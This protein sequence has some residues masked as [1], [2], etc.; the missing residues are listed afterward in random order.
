MLAIPHQERIRGTRDI[1][2][3]EHVS[4]SA[5]SEAMYA[6]VIAQANAS[7]KLM[8]SKR[9][10]K[11]TVLNRRLRPAYILLQPSSALGQTVCDSQLNVRSS[12]APASSRLITRRGKISRRIETLELLNEAEA[13]GTDLSRGHGLL[14]MPWHP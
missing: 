14:E 4:H 2:K 5:I 8:V 9:D 11:D 6:N 1:A 10:V 7:V 12:M 3:I 13:G